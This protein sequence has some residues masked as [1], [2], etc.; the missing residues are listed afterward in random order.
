MKNLIVLV[1]A[2]FSLSCTI[3]GSH[4]NVVKKYYTYA[5]A[6]NT[7]E[8]AKLLAG[9][10]MI[11]SPLSPQPMSKDEWLMVV[12][13]F[14]IGFS[15]LKHDVAAYTEAGNMVIARGILSGINDGPLMGK[16][17]M[18][19]QVNT[20][21]N[22]IFEL[23]K[24]LKI[25]A[26]YAQFDLKTFETQLAG[27][28]TNI[29]IEASKQNIHAAFDAL[30]RRDWDAF[31]ALCDADKFVDINVAPLPLLGVKEAVEG[32][33]QF[34]HAFP[35]F[36]LTISEIAVVNHKR[37][38]LRLTLTGTHQN[39]LMG[40]AASSKKINYEDCDI[41]EV[42][43]LGK[44][45]LHQPLKGGREVFR[46]IGVNPDSNTNAE[47]NIRAM[48]AATDV[49][50][51][52]KFMSFWAPDGVNYFGG[53]KTSGTE[54][55]DRISA[56]KAGFPDI[57]RSIEKLIVCDNTVTVHG[58]VSGTN[59]G[60]FRNQ[61]PTG[62][63]IKLYWIGVY[64]LDSEGKIESAWVEFDTKEMDKQLYGT[65]IKTVAGKN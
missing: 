47:A 45:I 59:S 17:P 63:T 61:D 53:K 38:L 41:V 58:W 39:E 35:D 26:I 32:Y 5:D 6:G 3:Q 18:G 11:S 64:S 12:Q 24:N 28:D 14:K 21:F 42:D 60:K 27:F 44:I 43:D 65:A 36:K 50:D 34:I 20:G 13:A 25:K 49:G 57:K 48:L 29:R 62:R 54:M 1:F 7:E 40:V 37:Y 9:N 4:I 55:K 33:K 52:E 30:N 8:V 51:L 10:F 2:Y 23:D 16:P 56:F 22:V 31:A 15:D 19:N 46:Q